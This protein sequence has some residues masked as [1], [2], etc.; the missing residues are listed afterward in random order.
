[1]AKTTAPKTADKP[2]E[3]P[4]APKARKIKAYRYKCHTTCFDQDEGKR[5]FAGQA[6]VTNEPLPERNPWAE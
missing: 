3:K 4:A 1:M 6:R 2:A 5:Y